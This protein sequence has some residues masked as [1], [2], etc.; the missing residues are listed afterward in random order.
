MTGRHWYLSQLRQQPT[1]LLLTLALGV[2]AVASALPTFAL[3]RYA[4]DVAIARREFVTLA[5]AA[6]GVVGLRLVGALLTIIIARPL[7][8]QSRALTAAL[9]YDLMAWIH[10]MQWSDLSSLSG[11]HTQAR[12]AHDAERIE[13]MSHGLFTIILPATVPLLCYAGVLAY[14]SLPLFVVVA[15]TGGI[16]RALA[17]LFARRLKRSITH[18]EHVYE[19]MHAG[20][21]SALRLLPSTRLHAGEDAMLRAHRHRVDDVSDAGSRMAL[22][23]LANT[24]AVGVGTVATA[25]MALLVGGYGV[26]I[27]DLTLGALTAFL[28]CA[29]QAAN[30]L[31]GALG[32]ASTLFAGD[33]ALSRLDKVHA[34]DNLVPEESKPLPPPALDGEIALQHVTFVHGDRTVLQDVNMVLER[35]DFAA[36]AAPNG[37]GKTTILA[38]ILGLLLPDRGSV[39]VA[40]ISL[41]ELDSR[42]LRQASGIVPQHPA[43]ITGSVRDNILLT[44][45]MPDESLYRA[46]RLSGLSSILG[47]LPDG[48]DTTVGEHGF[49]LSG[50][51]LQRLAI[52]RAIVH[53]PRLLILDEPTN[54]LDAEAVAGVLE[55]ILTSPDRPTILLASHDERLIA[56]ADR[57]YDLVGGR[58]I[59]RPALRRVGES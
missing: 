33:A 6:G 37:A 32:Q 10:R 29:S 22:A 4:I 7:I 13:L 19:M 11:A 9:R 52:A 41:A 24:Q 5:L 51:E 48:L 31:S 12:V 44:R 54:H 14:L 43:I 21:I 3:I 17:L 42:I 15:I 34:F 59:E 28:L 26:M 57:V 38:L 8:A 58:L 30:A 2:I 20:V 18:F 45:E 40:G 49:A 39:S 1:L 53:S 35:G 36:I 56:A 47:R 50:G 46:V 27:G 55:G 23:G 25:S 16:A